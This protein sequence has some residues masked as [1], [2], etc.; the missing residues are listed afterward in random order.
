MENVMPV[1]TP[2][3][4][5][6]PELHLGGEKL[7]GDL[8][9]PDRPDHQHL[10]RGEGGGR[11]RREGEGRLSSSARQCRYWTGNFIKF[12]QQIFILKPPVLTPLSA[13]FIIVCLSY[14]YSDYQ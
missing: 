4:I 10:A 1:L 11:R 7:D 5:S 14:Y 3:L 8:P 6:D 13:G 9:P 2:L 12:T